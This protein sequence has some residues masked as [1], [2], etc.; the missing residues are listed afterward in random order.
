MLLEPGRSIVGNAG[1]LLTRVEYIK[2]QS[3]KNFAVVDAAM[4]DLMRPAL[5]DAWHDIVA[6]SASNNP[7]DIYDI[8]G[9]VCESGDWLGKKRNLTIEEG[10][11]LAILSAGAYGMSMSS[12]Y[13]SRPRS[14]EIMVDKAA[15]HLIRSREK[16]DDLYSS[17]RLIQV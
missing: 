6:V 16:I 1:I 4:N 15:V 11:L 10:S 9:P 3:G 2:H 17:E 5:Y 7:A 8:V 12:N 14:A 13:N